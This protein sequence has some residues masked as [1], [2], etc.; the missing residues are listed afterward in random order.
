MD[1]F[2][3]S[4]NWKPSWVIS[5]LRRKVFGNW[6]ARFQVM[7]WWLC[8]REE[9]RKQSEWGTNQYS[10]GT[11]CGLCAI[12]DMYGTFSDI[13]MYINGMKLC[14]T[15]SLEKMQVSL[16]RY[17]INCN[18]HP[19]NHCI[20]CS[21][22]TYSP[23]SVFKMIRDRNIGCCGTTRCMWKYFPS[24]LCLKTRQAASLDW[25][26]LRSIIVNDVNCIC[27]I[28]N[29]PVLMLLTIHKIGPENTVETVRRRPRITPTISHKVRRVFGNAS[30]KRIAIP[31]LVYDYNHNMNGVNI[32][33]Q[34][35]SNYIT[36]IRRR[37]TW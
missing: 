8:S 2:S 14:S 34:L 29:G 16:L 17:V 5:A 25:D 33:D 12:G 36:H 27:W 13:Q 9:A 18:W 15:N 31:K 7:N 11:R 26:T 30:T 4:T 37:R 20:K 10:A 21:W 22:I 23:V 35:R 32:A 28:E 6:D 1:G 3:F 24:S 19:R